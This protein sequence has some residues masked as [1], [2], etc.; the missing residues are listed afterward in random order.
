MTESLC[1]NFFMERAEY[2]G[3]LERR[4]AYRALFYGNEGGFAPYSIEVSQM[5]L[6]EA[7]AATPKLRLSDEEDYAKGFMQNTVHK[8]LEHHNEIAS[9]PTGQ[10]A[11]ALMPAELPY[12]AKVTANVISKWNRTCKRQN[13]IS[14]FGTLAM[15]EVT[16]KDFERHDVQCVLETA[17]VVAEV[18]PLL[19]SERQ[20]NS[21]RTTELLSRFIT[22]HGPCF[23]R[24]WISGALLRDYCDAHGLD[25]DA[26]QAPLNRT[27]Y[28]YYGLNNGRAPLAGLLKFIDRFHNVL[29]TEALAAELAWPKEKVE[30][31]FTAANRRKIA[32]TN[33]KDAMAVARRT[34]EHIDSVIA[35]E[36]LATQCGISLE[37]A[38]NLFGWPERLRLAS[39]KDPLKIARQWV[40]NYDLLGANNLADM[41][42]LD[43]EEIAFLLTPSYR[44]YLATFTDS[45]L[46][47]LQLRAE[48]FKT[49]VTIPNISAELGWSESQAARIFSPAVRRT[50]AMRHPRHPERRIKAIA[51]IYT[52]LTAQ[53]PDLP[54]GMVASLSIRQ[55][56]QTAVATAA[57]LQQEYQRTP[58]ANISRKVWLWVITRNPK[59]NHEEWA[60]AANA[61]VSLLRSLR[62]PVT[63]SLQSS[64]KGRAEEDFLSDP[65]ANIEETLFQDEPGDFLQELA[66]RAGVPYDS[67]G[68]ILQRY[69]AG[70]EALP[71]DLQAMLTKLQIAANT[72]R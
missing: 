31:V 68:E 69:A 17:S 49:K 55:S 38:A 3:W 65:G 56:R 36:N 24:A 34:A 2:N 58:P 14:P 5:P 43:E 46:D 51:K 57:L 39:A 48:A 7:A 1:Y 72:R 32:R 21:E 40:Q 12:V 13:L 62:P 64:R 52:G 10:A 11:F 41:L 35:V 42:G 25:A 37:R 22:V 19:L 63:V 59:G 9:G 28:I 15:E 30:R 70:D 33:A 45:L 8:I 44:R 4:E 50:I 67:L 20:K 60:K 16:A 66:E 18:S 23:A 29:S 61:Y 6:A 47:A 27:I 26:Y 54:A 71:A 53:Y